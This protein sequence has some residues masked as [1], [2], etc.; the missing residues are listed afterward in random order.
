[1]ETRNVL[2]RGVIVLILAGLLIGFQAGST[3]ASSTSIVISQVYG[4]GGNSGAVYKNDFIELFNLGATPVS[5]A[6]WSVQYASATGTGNFGSNPVTQLLGTLQPG[7][8]LLIQEA[9]GAG[10]SVDL[11]TPDVTGTVNMSGT[12]GK[13]VLVNTTTGLPCNGGSAPCTPAQL[14]EIV[15]LVGWDGANFFETSPGPATNNT[16]ALLRA[17]GGLQDTDINSVD[18]IAGTPTP[19]NTTSPFNPN[20]NPP[21][22]PT[23]EPFTMLLLGS[24]L[25]GLVGLKRHFKK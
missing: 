13:V 16:T 23:P 22:T 3:Q 5:L 17:T 21:P 2:L 20:P 1:M 18:F 9:A 7:Q 24:G 6:G 4:G 12:G 15:D 14:V 10:G 19:R 11:P 8:Y 25:F